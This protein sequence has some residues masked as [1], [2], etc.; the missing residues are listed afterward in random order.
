MDSCPFALRTADITS[1]LPSSWRMESSGVSILP[2]T[3]EVLTDSLLVFVL[4][5]F[6]AVA[7]F[8]SSCQTL[9]SLGITVL[10]MKS[11]IPSIVNLA[12]FLLQVKWFDPWRQD[13]SREGAVEV[14]SRTEHASLDARR[15]PSFWSCIPLSNCLKERCLGHT[16][17]NLA[18]AG[19]PTTFLP[20]PS[21][22]M[23]KCKLVCKSISVD[24]QL[25]L[26]LYKSCRH[27][28]QQQHFSSCFSAQYTDC[29]SRIWRATASCGVSA[30]L[31]PA[32]SL[33][34]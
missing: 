25:S 4:L 1:W 15:I 29:K 20:F 13:R 11:W 19:L 31:L 28:C 9:A 14:N 33:N 34:R 26:L 12:N 2:S 3:T 32:T 23:L 24:S 16:K 5:L 22:Y 18:F 8:W 27:L 10:T 30:V 6:F 17:I 21:I 7:T